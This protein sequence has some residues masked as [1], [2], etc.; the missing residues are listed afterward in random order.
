MADASAP[1]LIKASQA[2]VAVAEGR[3]FVVECRGERLIITAAHCLPHLPPIGIHGTV[4]LEERTFANLVGPLGA[5]R[6]IWAECRY[7]EVVSDLAILGP[8]D[9]Q[10]RWE[11]A[12]AYDGF[13]EQCA[14]I[15]IGDIDSSG[16]WVFSLDRAWLPC[17]PAQPAVPDE[18]RAARGDGE[19]LIHSGA[20]EGG[21]SG[22][23]RPRISISGRPK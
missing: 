3:G 6:T 22:S 21:M 2:I 5:E 10:E 17:G 20:V 23:R 13:V 19:L 4:G 9:S 11:E 12:S 18:F 7:A 16:L 1:E 8:P 15:S 14:A